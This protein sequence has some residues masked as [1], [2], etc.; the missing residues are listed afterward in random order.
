MPTTDRTKELLD[1][2]HTAVE[3]TM[4]N[5]DWRS[6][7]TLAAKFHKYS[8]RNVWLIAAQFPEAS[9]VAGFTTWKQ[10][11]RF[12]KKGEKGIAILAPM[13]QRVTTEDDEPTKVLRGFRVVHVFDVSQT[14][15][16]PLPE[17]KRPQQLVGGA[18]ED[19]ANDLAALIGTM[20]YEVRYPTTWPHGSANG[21][22]VWGA[23]P[24]YV[25]I[26]PW[27]EPAQV[28]KT[29]A[30]ELAHVMLHCERSGSLSRG[31][32]EVEA[33]S[34]AF[35]VCTAYGMDTTVYSFPYIAEWSGGDIELVHR[36]ATR[37]MDTANRILTALE[38]LI[39]GRGDAQSA[40][41]STVS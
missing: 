34:V 35:V 16:E 3:Q 15:G 19:L 36:T 24:K 27:L 18:P 23:D 37:V 1:T 39:E 7:L 22:T 13:I 30:H 21:I 31:Q 40:A 28:T 11:G 9:Y 29:T 41:L 5:E 32:M 20:G 33:E 10:M 26:N 17:G 12:V 6:W 25:E 8:S 14:D 4:Q 2:L 38:V